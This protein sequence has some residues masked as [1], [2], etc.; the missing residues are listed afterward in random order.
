MTALWIAVAVLAAAWCGLAWVVIEIHNE[1]Y[2]IRKESSGYTVVRV[3]SP[4]T[5][6]SVWG[7]RAT[8]ISEK[9]RKLLEKGDL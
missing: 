7:P 6:I 4:A 3:G 2:H 5:S 9:L 8:I 1:S